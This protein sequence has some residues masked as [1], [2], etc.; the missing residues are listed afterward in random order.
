MRAQFTIG[1]VLLIA[2]LIVTFFAQYLPKCEYGFTNQLL[3]FLPYLHELEMLSIYV[4]GIGYIL[5]F[6][7][8]FR[9]YREKP[10][11]IKFFRILLLTFFGLFTVTL[12][13]ASMNT[14]RS[15]G[16]HAELK[17]RVASTRAIAEI[18]LGNNT[19]NGYYGFCNT[20]EFQDIKESFL[21]QKRISKICIQP[22]DVFNCN[23][24]KDAYA[25]S[26]KIM[27]KGDEGYF[28]ADSTGFAGMIDS[29]IVGIKCK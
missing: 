28:C 15:K 27:E 26:G 5:L 10:W 13:L 22:T 23:D 1:S 16:L 12:L 19:Q 29:P 6:W 2:P 20:T 17:L 18:H 3:N 9:R 21:K 24:S 25:V 7:W 8:I 4:C 11:H 14:A